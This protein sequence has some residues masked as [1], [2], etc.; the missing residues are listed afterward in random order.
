MADHFGTIL[1]TVLE[2]NGAS[3]TAWEQSL[4]V[5]GPE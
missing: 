3:W 5:D 1:C 4:I 2:D